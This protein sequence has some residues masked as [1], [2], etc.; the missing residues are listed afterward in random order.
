MAAVR[1]HAH[2]RPESA[3]GHFRTFA[4][5]LS[6]MARW[7][8]HAILG[9]YCRTWGC[10][11][12]MLWSDRVL[13]VRDMLQPVHVH[14]IEVLVDGD[15]NHGDAGGRS[16]PVLLARRDPHRIAGP[17]LA[18][19]TAPGLHASNARDDVQRLTE[20]VRVPSGPRA[21]CEGHAHG[22]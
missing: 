20:R 2:I 19:R 6:A 15:V 16:M 22:S 10:L 3:M 4:D 13:F 9:P 8:S 11:G 17:D 21:G 1:P 12:A 18:H 14:A 7:L 5:A